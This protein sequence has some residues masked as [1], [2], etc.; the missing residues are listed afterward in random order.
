MSSPSAYHIVFAG[1]GT[2][3]HLFPGIATAERLGQ[4]LPGVR[5]TFAGT[6]RPFERRAVAEAGFDYLTLRCHAWPRRLW[7]V[8]PFVR[9]NLAGYRAAQR[10]LEE[11]C[12][13]AVVGLGGFASAPMAR[14]ALRRGIPLALLEQ[15]VV[16]GRVTR[17]LSRSATFVCA[18][19]EET[20]RYLDPRSAVL[21]TGNPIRAAFVPKAGRTAPAGHR[22]SDDGCGN[23][24]GRAGRAAPPAALDP[25]RQRRRPVAQ[26]KRPAGIRP[27]SLGP[28]RLGDRPSDRPERCRS[29][30]ASLPAARTTSHRRPLPRR[31]G[32]GLSR[33]RS[34]G[35]PGWRHDASRASRDG[36]A[37]RA[38][39]LSARRRRSSAQERRALRRLGRLP[40]DPRASPRGRTDRAPGRHPRA[41]LGRRGPLP[42]ECPKRS[43][44]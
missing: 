17:W 20:T 43:A 16:P 23:L 31:P 41:T 10:F 34:G 13:T 1:G 29:D 12:V 36:R 30:A 32:V 9:E 11:Q 6:G 38:V 5:I 3:G 33:H 40:G 42:G 21:V 39:A 44:A 14:A 28:G 7:Q 22:G 15:N 19:L 27:D 4:E 35:L 26:R 2:G 8:V 18:A 25:R 37:G 24:V